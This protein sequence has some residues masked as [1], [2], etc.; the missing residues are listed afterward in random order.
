M[1]IDLIAKLPWTYW[2]LLAMA[3][4]LAIATAVL[5]PRRGRR[6]RRSRP[7]TDDR[8]FLNQGRTKRSWAE[9]VAQLQGA[10]GEAQTLEAREETDLY[11]IWKR[12]SQAEAGASK[13]DTTKWSLDL[14]RA[15]EWK[16]FETLSAAYFEALGLKARVAGPGSDGGVDIRLFQGADDKPSI[17]VQCKAWSTEPVGVAIVRELYGVMKHQD[18]AEGIVMTTSTFTPDARDF[19]KSSDLHLIDGQDLLAKIL[20][21]PVQQ[22]LALLRHATAGDFTT[23]TCPSCGSTMVARK[24]HGRSTGFWGCPR[25]PVCRAKLQMRAQ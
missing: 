15:L 6:R 22:Q 21:L 18:V 5:R 25:F 19:P 8:H 23:P 14:L 20:A 17:L 2:A 9:E 7:S 11:D 3:A 1:F 24:G 13:I 4:M 10:K 12:S 16:R